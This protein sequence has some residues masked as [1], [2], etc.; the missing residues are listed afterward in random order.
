MVLG[1]DNA[2]TDHN[3]DNPALETW[4]QLHGHHVAR[5]GAGER[6]PLLPNVERTGRGDAS[7]LQEAQC[8]TL[9]GGESGGWD[10]AQTVSV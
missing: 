9:Q 10:G 6:A 2:N 5:C 8:I 4:M 7:R 1:R 3:I